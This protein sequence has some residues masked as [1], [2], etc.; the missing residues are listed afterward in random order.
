[1]TIRR[2]GAILAVWILV[3]L[4]A[5]LVAGQKPNQADVQ[6]KAAMSKELVDGDLK[7][8][9][10][11]Y[12]KIIATSGGNRNIVAQALVQM[13]QCYEK[14]GQ[15][16]ARSA[17][18][19]VLREFADQ[20]EPARLARQRLAAL[21][22]V[23]T[24]VPASSAAP[25]MTV[26]RVWSQHGT[27]A[28]VAGPPS[29]DGHYL[30]YYN[31]DMGDIWVHDFTTG[32]NRRLFLKKGDWD[33]NEEATNPVF[34]PDSRRLAYTWFNAKSYEL[35]VSDL[36]GAQPRVIYSNT[37]DLPTPYAWTPDATSLL[38]ILRGADEIW[39]IAVVSAADG[40]SRT[41]RTLGREV[42]PQLALPPDGRYVAYS[43][44]PADGSR[45]R[46][47]FTIEVATG[48]EA[49]VVEH[50]A[51]DQV[52]AWTPDGRRL[53][54]SA[55]GR[56]RD[57]WAIDVGR[58][59]PG[60]PTSSRSGAVQSSGSSSGTLAR[61]F[62]VCA[63]SAATLDF[64]TGGVLILHGPRRRTTGWNHNPDWSWDGQFLAFTSLRRPQNDR[65]IVFQSTKT[66][67]ERD[68]KLAM[69]D[70]TPRFG[71]RWAPDGRFV[72]I[73][74]ALGTDT[75]GL[76][77]VDVQTGAVTHLVKVAAIDRL[78]IRRRRRVR[79]LHG[80]RSEDEPARTRVA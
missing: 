53:L 27:L 67:E 69:K 10:E 59:A 34:A 19:R 72:L 46:D 20:S 48:R 42:S 68:V 16:E 5:A 11:L 37:E 70:A 23:A 36:D 26:R 3:F 18:E 7:G 14:L 12:Q 49:A 32:Q 61:R 52:L 65:F 6:L 54:F 73:E 77:Q 33:S 80:V 21:A 28:T 64:A 66:G 44:R 38:C 50:G 8:A 39:R 51:D 47:V 60:A 75:C 62:P 15:K 24:A 35:R 43:R 58:V 56:A 13:G 4:A 17:Y 45:Q 55:T 22:P 63:R 74:A 1:M 71:L 78:R 79:V 76:A 25:D 41:L 29:P 2:T 31:G 40:S 30:P 9:I 57:A